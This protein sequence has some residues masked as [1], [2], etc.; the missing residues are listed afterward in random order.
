VAR[1]EK[2]R[3]VLP[4][5]L[6]DRLKQSGRDANQTLFTLMFAAFGVLIHHYSGRDEIL[7][8][9]AGSGRTMRET[10]N[11]IGMFAGPLVVRASFTANPTFLDLLARIRESFL[12]AVAHVFPARR[13]MESMG[14]DAEGSSRSLSQVFF[15]S[16]PDVPV[17]L[18]LNGLES[19]SYFPTE[20]ERMRHDLEFYTRPVPNGMY[21]ALWC[22]RAIFDSSVPQRMMEDYKLLLERIADNPAESIGAL[23]QGIPAS[24]ECAEKVEAAAQ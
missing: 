15:D 7:M 12:G 18:D 17:S 14:I 23:L 2:C 5:A 11:L 3:I 22:S 1:G 8:L 24:L 10:E 4:Q 21:C 19:A 9:T 20:R 16:L 13:L 6:I